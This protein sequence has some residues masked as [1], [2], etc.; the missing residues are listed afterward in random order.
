MM[1]LKTKIDNCFFQLK[2]QKKG[3]EQRTNIMNNYKNGRYQFS[4]AN[5][6]N[7]PKKNNLYM[8]I[9]GQRLLE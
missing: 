4:Y 9:K 8:S 1:H 3:G 2:E 5:N 7:T 6:L